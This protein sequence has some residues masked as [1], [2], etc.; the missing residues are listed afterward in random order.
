MAD[1]RALKERARRD[2]HQHLQVPAYYRASPTAEWQAVH[3]RH[4]RQT[5]RIGDYPGLEGALMRDLT[6]RIIFMR[7]EVAMPARGGV[8]SVATG[9]AYTIGDCEPPDG[10]TITAHVAPVPAA[11]T[12]GFPVP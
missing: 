10:I 9:E 8:V 12:T 1:L 7:D 6:P 3:I 4:H 11:S 5:Q 2:L